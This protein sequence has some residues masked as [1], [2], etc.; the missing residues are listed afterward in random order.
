MLGEKAT[1]WGDTEALCI[2]L[3]YNYTGNSKPEVWGSF[4]T[5]LELTASRPQA[6]M[7]PI[8]QV[9]WATKPEPKAT[10]KRRAPRKTQ[11]RKAK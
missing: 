5:D 2:S 8:S 6:Y 1:I 10:P 4:T 7:L 11:T 9:Q 3:F